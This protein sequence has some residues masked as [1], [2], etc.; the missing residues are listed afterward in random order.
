MQD[1]H[2]VGLMGRTS[3]PSMA[4]GDSPWEKLDGVFILVMRPQML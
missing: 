4:F 3:I 1:L 2:T